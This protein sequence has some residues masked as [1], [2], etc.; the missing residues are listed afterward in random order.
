[1][2]PAAAVETTK[3]LRR[4]LESCLYNWK[5]SAAETLPL[6]LAVPAVRRALDVLP[7]PADEAAE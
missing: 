7:T 6:V 2:K 1:M 4:C 3:A 5:T